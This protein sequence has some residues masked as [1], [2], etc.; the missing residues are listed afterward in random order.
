MVFLRG[1]LKSFGMKDREEDFTL[2]AGFHYDKL[3][4][5]DIS[6]DYAFQNFIHLGD[7]HTFGF[8]LKF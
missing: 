5:I 8:L 6:I 3:D 4:F 2:G 7:V 1:G